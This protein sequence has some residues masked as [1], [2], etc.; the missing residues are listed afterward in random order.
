MC[1]IDRQSILPSSLVQYRPTSYLSLTMVILTNV[2]M[3]QP[4]AKGSFV[5]EQA[6][7]Y[8]GQQKYFVCGT[9]LLMSNVLWYIISRGCVGT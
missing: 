7:Q 2:R 3:P 9:Y 4:F 6:V 8:N 5:E 1:H